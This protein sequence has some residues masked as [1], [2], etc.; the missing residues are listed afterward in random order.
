MPTDSVERV[1][2]FCSSP[3]S[4]DTDPPCLVHSPFGTVLVVDDEADGREIVAALL[5]PHGYKLLFA[6]D[7]RQALQH[8]ARCLPDV[9]LLDVMMPDVD[10]FTVCEQL[11]ADSLLAAIPIILITAL[12]DRESRLRGLEAGADDF[13]SKPVDPAEL[14]VRV[15]TIVRLNRYHRLLEERQR[16]LAEQQRTAHLAQQTVVTLEETYDLTLRGWVKALALRDD[17]TEA[18]SQRVTNLTLRLAQAMGVAEEQMIHIWRGALLHDIGKL[19]IPDAVLHKSGALNAAEHALMRQHPIYAYEWLSSI[20]FL[21]PALDIPHYHHEKW[22]GSGYPY[23]LRGKAIPLTARIFAVVD[24][25]DA[26]THDR[27][28]RAA[29]PAAQVRDYIQQQAGHHFDPT[30]VTTF[31]SLL[32]SETCDVDHLKLEHPPATTPQL[33][34]DQQQ[35]GG[36]E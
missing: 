1:V 28:Y 29:L 11:R 10:G 35:Q 17:E 27:P 24:V 23:G 2:Q 9:V 25:W 32:H 26:L 22:D 31:L 4:A 16:V 3:D 7:G 18:H 14:V 30:V 34:T 13:L 36:Q 12:N 20:P 33:L 15:R 8:A 6:E 5:R 19:G 21:R